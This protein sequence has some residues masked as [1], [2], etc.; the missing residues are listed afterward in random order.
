MRCGRHAGF[1]VGASAHE[2]IS[3]KKI[4]NAIS[5]AELAPRLRKRK[6]H[7]LLRAP[8]REVIE[9]IPEGCAVVLDV[10]CGKG[11]LGRWLKE[12]PGV[13]TVYGAEL[14]PAAG[15]EARR[16]LDDVVVGN[17]EH[18]VLPFPEGTVDCI[19]CADVLEHTADPWAVVAK[20]KK[21]L[22]PDGCIVASIPNVGFHRNIRKMLRGQWTYAQEGLLD[23][24][25]LRFFTLETITEL[26]ASNGLTIERVFK[27]VDAGWNVRILNALTFGYLKNTLYLHYI[28]RV[29]R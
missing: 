12:Q 8:A 19:I 22:K 18:V 25:H 21:L 16:W 17:I 20:L 26:F 11:T 9:A 27:K 2:A 7:R 10:G 14:F 15:E 1:R 5:P 3:L 13:T 6:A 28:V 4:R 29:R 23:K 24:T